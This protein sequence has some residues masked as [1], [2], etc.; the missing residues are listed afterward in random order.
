MKHTKNVQEQGLEFEIKALD[1]ES[2]K[3]ARQN[4]WTPGKR[5]EYTEKGMKTVYVWAK[6]GPSVPT[7]ETSRPLARGAKLESIPQKKK[8]AL[9]K[10][11]IYN[12]EENMKKRE[13]E[14]RLVFDNVTLTVAW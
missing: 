1:G 3:K 4:V 7:R 10:V 5:T 2:F 9:C 8:F 13:T 12:S 11:E 14:G 6:L